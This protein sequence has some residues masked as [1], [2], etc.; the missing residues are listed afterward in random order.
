MIGHLY[1]FF[2]RDFKSGKFFLTIGKT[3]DWKSRESQYKTTNANISFDYLKEVKHNYL[4][5]AESDLKKYLKE[6]YPIWKT[7]EEQFEIGDGELDVA[8]AEKVLQEVLNKVKTKGNDVVGI[9]YQYGTL[10]GVRDYR[11]LRLPCDMIPGK[12]SMIVT[13]AGVKERQ[14]KYFTKYEKKGRRLIKLNTP[15]RLNISNEA[16]D[17][18][19]VVQANERD[20]ENDGETD[21]I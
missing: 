12:V 16:W 8:K 17:I 10:F 7:S 19:Q 13:K 5:E 18:I 4:T 3:G 9:D 14:R 21:I 11:D 2:Q 15:K 6:H 20:K 1:G